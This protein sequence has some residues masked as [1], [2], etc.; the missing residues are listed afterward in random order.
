VNTDIAGE[1]KVIVNL[2]P[3]SGLLLASSWI[4]RSQIQI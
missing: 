1:H 3:H 4:N 2:E